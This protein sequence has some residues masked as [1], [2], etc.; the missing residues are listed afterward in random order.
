[1]L[2]LFDIRFQTFT[3][4]F[5]LFTWLETEAI[6]ST[7]KSNECAIIDFDGSIRKIKRHTQILG[8]HQMMGSTWNL[9]QL[10]QIGSGGFTTE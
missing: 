5:T 9:E 7:Q 3:K 8:V 10:K 6:F 4:K 1:M 2:V